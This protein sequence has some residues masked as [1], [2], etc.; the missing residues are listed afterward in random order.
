MSQFTI[1]LI[2]GPDDASATLITS[3]KNQLCHI[4]FFYDGRSI[5]AS[6]TDYF[7]ALCEIRKQL[8]SENLIPFCYG[9]SLNVY[10]SGMCRDMGSG[11]KA[12]KFKLGQKPTLS[13]LVNIFDSGFDVIPS[14]V[15]KQ[16][17]YFQECWKA[18]QA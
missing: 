12:Y 7:E 10:P 8:E 4:D 6:A 17:E 5:Q 1:H 15:S 3:T 14:Y 13:D 11:L 2:G 18:I 9:A 16:K